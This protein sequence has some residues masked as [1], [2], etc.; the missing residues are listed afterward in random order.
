[1]TAKNLANVAFVIWLCSLALPGI[2]L[3]FH[4]YSERHWLSGYE[5]LFMGWLS[6]LVGNFAWFANLFFLYAFFQL[7]AGRMPIKSSIFA[8]VLSLDTFRFDEY[9]MNEGGS[10]T[11]VYGYGWGAILWFL[12]IT[13]LLTAVG[14]QQPDSGENIERP[15]YEWLRPL[16]IFLT[17]LTLG[18]SGFFAI[19]DRIMA[20]PTEA[21]RLANIAFKRGKICSVPEPVAVE[22]I[23]SFSGT[24]EIVMDKNNIKTINANYPFRQIKDLLSWGIPSVRFYGNDY[25]FNSGASDK[26]VIS[27]P[28]AGEP[29]AT[30]YIDETDGRVINAKLVETISRR[31]VFDQTWEKESLNENTNFHFCPDYHS[32]PSANDQP[33]KLLVQAL[34]LPIID[35]RDGQ[36]YRQVASIASFEGVVTEE[37]DDGVTRKMR[38]EKW[39]KEIDPNF[40][41][42]TGYMFKSS[43]EFHEWFNTNCPSDTGWDGSNQ[44]TLQH[45]GW[46]FMVNGKAYYP[47]NR[48]GRN[49]AT[50]V[51]DVAYLYIGGMRNDK[52]YYLNISKRTIPDFRQTWA[53]IILIPNIT[54]TMR[55]NLLE[56]QSIKEDN[57]VM[58][59]K[60]VNE[61]TGKTLL[62]QASLVKL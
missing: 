57:G 23:R 8:A 3:Y 20:N 21:A 24:L 13:L 15:E 47:T 55:D 33:R 60:L 45:T 25:S 22:P 51:D 42:G 43:A 18:A 5:I 31:V 9:M 35:R 30:L 2:D 29:A 28:A 40:K 61:D 10:T 11:P 56:I 39:K 41:T 32:F 1:M 53:G 46:A 48:S 34:S 26:T 37:T 54:T 49:Y 19:H 17:V 16:G 38:F 52:K 59:I 12:S 4:M 50:C 6:P 27:K 44:E 58:T 36:E 62:V 7:K 14:T